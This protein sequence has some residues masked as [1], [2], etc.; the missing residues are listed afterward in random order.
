M[1]LLL[2]TVTLYGLI[3]LVQLIELDKLTVVVLAIITTIPISV[4]MLDYDFL[5]TNFKEI[6]IVGILRAS[7]SICYFYSYDIGL[8]PVVISMVFLM[9]ILYSSGAS[10]L[11]RCPKNLDLVF[12]S[13]IGTFLLV[14]KMP[15][16]EWSISLLIPLGSPVL[17]AISL[18]YFR[19]ILKSDT[20]NKTSTIVGVRN[21]ITLA[22]IVLFFGIEVNE[23]D[24]EGVVWSALYGILILKFAMIGFFHA[25]KM[26][27]PKKYSVIMNLEFV[28]SFVVMI[29]VFSVGIKPTQWIGLIVVTTSLGILKRREIKS[30]R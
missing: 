14:N 25:S 13:S 27:D 7:A 17:S 21:V 29:F 12:L 20:I 2:L 5:R 28:I 18:L 24:I 10:L 11:D 23:I 19:K 22:M 8:G 16:F 26:I 4:R 15:D 30:T 9:P 6:F 1:H 3:P